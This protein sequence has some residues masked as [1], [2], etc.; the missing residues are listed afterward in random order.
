MGHNIKLV[1]FF[2]VLISFPAVPEASLIVGEE[3]IYYIIRKGDTLELI[4]AKHGRQWQ[5]IAREN[6]IDP[7][8]IL[9]EGKIIKINTR[10]IVPLMIEDGIIIN[11][12]ERMLY[13]F[14]E[15]KLQKYFPVGL[16]MPFWREFTRWRTPTGKFEI[17]GKTKNPTWYVPESMQWKMMME[18]EPVRTVVPPGPDNPLGRYNIRTSIP[19]IV[20]HETIWPT[21]VYQFRSHG[22]IRVLPEHMEDFFDKVEINTPG[23]IIYNPIK[24]AL[25]DGR[26]YL[27]AHRDIYRKVGDLK[28]EALRL[29]EEAGVSDKIDNIKLE[30]VLKEKNGIPEDISLW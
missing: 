24:V 6:N 30:R 2:L 9:R 5:I 4:G 29:I 20:I 22:C 23:E 7:E 19:N 25:V 16:G 8:K 11:I 26:I 10:R 15:G 28:K 18:G 3:D 27:E 21:T 17:I 12:P 13:Y 1:T 14:K